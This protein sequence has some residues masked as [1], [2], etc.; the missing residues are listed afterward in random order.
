MDLLELE[1][2]VST[3]VGKFF[4]HGTDNPRNLEIT[5]VPTKTPDLVDIFSLCV[6]LKIFDGLPVFGS[7]ERCPAHSG[8]RLIEG[9]DIVSWSNLLLQKVFQALVSQHPPTPRVYLGAITSHYYRDQ[10]KKGEEIKLE[11]YWMRR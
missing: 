9:M 10:Y 11:V 3:I 2:L 8:C 1:K 6:N 4:S 5:I 7:L